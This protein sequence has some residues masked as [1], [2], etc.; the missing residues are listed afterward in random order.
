MVA[1][2]DPL[3]ALPNALEVGA[4][5][6]GPVE[7]DQR[8]SSDQTRGADLVGVGGVDRADDRERA[9]DPLESMRRILQHHHRTRLVDD[10]ARQLGMTGSRVCSPSVTDAAKSEAASLHSPRAAF[11]E[12][13]LLSSEARSR[14]CPPRRSRIASATRAQRSPAFEVVFHGT[15]DRHQLDGGLGGEGIVAYGLPELER[16]LEDRRRAV[17]IEG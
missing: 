13:R 16:L 11:S 8:L 17:R 5:L 3:E 2:Q 4:G 7:S 15:D 14:G 12:P 6:G 9:V 1:A 10:R